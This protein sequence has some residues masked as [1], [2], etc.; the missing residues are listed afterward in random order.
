MIFFTFTNYFSNR[1]FS[2]Y[3]FNLINILFKQKVMIK[4]RR[5]RLLKMDWYPLAYDHLTRRL[6]VHMTG[7]C[8]AIRRHCQDRHSCWYVQYPSCSFYQFLFVW[9]YPKQLES[10]GSLKPMLLMYHPTPTLLISLYYFLPSGDPK[11]TDSRSFHVCSYLLLYFL[12]LMGRLDSIVR[13]WIDFDY[14]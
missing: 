12:I 7:S 10:Y 4:I 1:H 6:D 8:C 3:A 9:C 14:Y 2:W 11:S 5:I 13:K